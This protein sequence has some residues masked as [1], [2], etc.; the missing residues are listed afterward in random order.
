MIHRSITWSREESVVWLMS[1]V[2]LKGI[3][4]VEP[5]MPLLE[6][7]VAEM[8]HRMFFLT[9]YD[10]HHVQNLVIKKK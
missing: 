1:E 10:T 9:L 5:T 8:V 7:P 2:V 6:K 4:K 3:S